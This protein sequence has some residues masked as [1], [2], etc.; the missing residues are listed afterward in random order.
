MRKK[1]ANELIEKTNNFDFNQ[2]KLD[3]DQVV[4]LT[5]SDG[6]FR[7]AKLTRSWPTK[8]AYFRSAKPTRSW[9]PLKG[10]PTLVF[11]NIKTNFLLYLYLRSLNE[12]E[13]IQLNYLRL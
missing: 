2:Y 8:S 11:D 4:G 9:G 3:N 12:T 13:T 10:P 5:D 6:N 7:S 1:Y